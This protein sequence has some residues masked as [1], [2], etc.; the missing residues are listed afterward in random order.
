MK[1]LVLILLF[2]VSICHAYLA[3]MDTAE[4]V[5]PKSYVANVG[6]QFAPGSNVVGRLDTG[7][8]ENSSFRG[9][10]GMG[11]VDVFLGGF[12]KWAP[13]PD[14]ENGQPGLGIITGPIYARKSNTSI[15]HYRVTGVGSKKFSGSW[16]VVTPYVSFSTGI[17]VSQERT[18]APTLLALGSEVAPKALKYVKFMGEIGAGLTEAFNYFNL[19]AVFS[20]DVFK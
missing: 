11:S 7:I 6:L 20:L 12:Y 13:I 14:V 1:Y 17:A 2:N 5:A 3:T 19:A 9:V 16:G 4:L 10:V 8:D 15:L 18:Y